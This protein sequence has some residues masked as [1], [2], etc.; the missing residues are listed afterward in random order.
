[1]S[2]AMRGFELA[3]GPK[4]KL[5]AYIYGGVNPDGTADRTRPISIGTDEELD[6]GIRYRAIVMPVRVPAR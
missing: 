4:S 2:D 3:R 5:P 6:T 1:M